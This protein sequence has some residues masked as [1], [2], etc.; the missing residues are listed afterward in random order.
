MSRNGSPLLL[1]L[2]VLVPACSSGFDFD[3]LS[4]DF[5]KPC[6]TGV[7]PNCKDVA[8]GLSGL[9]VE[10]PCMGDAMPSYTC[11]SAAESVKTTT[12]G[13]TPGTTYSLQLQFRGIVELNTYGPG[14]VMDFPFQAGGTDSSGAYNTY[15]L[16]VTDPPQTYFL[17]AVASATERHAW[18]DRVNKM[19]TVRAKALASVTLRGDANDGQTIK[20]ID[21]AMNPLSSPVGVEP[22]ATPFPGQFMQIDV[23]SVTVSP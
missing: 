15:A 17:N 19:A 7:G 14:E 3:G 5:G 20:N 1:A 4:G 11:V 2:I 18:S 16:D 12:L 13:G 9:R 22:S 21:S 10:L 6:T 23:L 8:S